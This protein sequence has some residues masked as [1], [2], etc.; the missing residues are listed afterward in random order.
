M[1]L[2]F[3]S[4]EKKWNI[5]YEQML[6]KHDVV[7]RAPV[8]DPTYGIPLGDG[9]TGC[10]LWFS[11]QA[12]NINL[13][14][15]DLWNDSVADTGFLCS[16]KEEE[17]TYCA[18]GAHLQLDFGC[19]VFEMIFQKNFEARL[20]LADALASISA[21]TPFCKAEIGNLRICLPRRPG[22][23]APRRCGIQ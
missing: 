6:S 8:C 14:K 18:H 7:F 13:N 17:L 21:H 1:K 9:D 12:L 5:P 15:T 20:S 23:G 3:N 16:N 10:L 22:H 2:Q 11:E 4:K 19:P